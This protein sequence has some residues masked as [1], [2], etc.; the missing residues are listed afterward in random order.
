LSCI[1]HCGEDSVR[2]ILTEA[3]PK[4]KEFIA[5]PEPEELCS[6]WFCIRWD[7]DVAQKEL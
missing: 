3:L 7:E 2:Q 6:L 1:Q 4:L 5:V